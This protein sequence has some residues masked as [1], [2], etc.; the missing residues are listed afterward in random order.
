[1][2]TSVT[3]L[4]NSTRAPASGFTLLEVMVVVAII[5]VMLVVVRISLPDRAADALKLEAQR[6]VLTL[7]DCR[8]SAVLSGTPAGI[9]IVA[10]RYALERYQRGWRA[11]ARGGND[12]P[13]VLADEVELTVPPPRGGKVAPGPAVVC[14]PSGETRMANIMLSHRRERGYYRFHDNVDGEFI[15]TWMAPA[16]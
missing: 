1:M 13:R 6:F 16:T 15:A 10:G 3:G 12:A 4:S 14:L 8:D 7:N 5:S 9:R 2:P 11:V